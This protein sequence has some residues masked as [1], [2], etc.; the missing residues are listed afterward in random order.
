MVVAIPRA[1]CDHAEI[2][3]AHLKRF[4]YRHLLTDEAR[5]LL[6]KGFPRVLGSDFHPGNADL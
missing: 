5:F 2:W 4:G 3:E 6:E 1:H